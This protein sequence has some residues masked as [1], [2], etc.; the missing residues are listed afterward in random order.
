M[1]RLISLFV[2]LILSAEL[3]LNQKIDFQELGIRDWKE[4]NLHFKDIVVFEWT[5]FDCPYV[6]KHYRSK[7]MQSLQEEFKDKITW[8]TVVSSAEGKEG[9]IPI[10]RVQEQLTSQEWKGDYFV[11]DFKGELG[12][13]F[14]AKTTPHIFIFY[15]GSL[16]YKGAIDSIPSTKESDIKVATNY[17]KKVVQELLDSIAEGV[18]P[19]VTAF[20]TKP[21]GCSV[22]Y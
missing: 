20:E 21:Y 10:E 12:K 14:G 16:I 19:Q 7:N 5:N 13:K 9:F 11:R 18:E 17:V 8:V 6:K 4:E 22:K 15:K 2:T 3:A 1:F